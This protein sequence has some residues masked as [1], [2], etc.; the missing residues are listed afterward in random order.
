MMTLVMP[1]FQTWKTH[2]TNGTRK[3]S[4]RTMM[5]PFTETLS[6]QKHWNS[7]IACHNITT[8]NPP[9]STQTGSKHIVAAMASQSN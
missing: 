6:K 9:S 3:P 1:T 5:V 2:Y 7:G 8:S 4:P